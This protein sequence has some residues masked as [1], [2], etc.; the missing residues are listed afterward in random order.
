MNH[1]YFN[2][3]LNKLKGCSRYETNQNPCYVQWYETN[4]PKD[5][6]ILISSTPLALPLGQYQIR[7]QNFNVFNAIK[8]VTRP[9]LK[10]DEEIFFFYPKLDSEKNTKS[11]QFNIAMY[12]CKR[13]DKL[14]G[15]STVMC[16]QFYIHTKKKKSAT[17]GTKKCI[18]S[19]N[20]EL[21]WIFIQLN[22]SLFLLFFCIADLKFFPLFHSPDRTHISIHTWIETH[23]C[24]FIVHIKARFIPFIYLLPDLCL[25]ATF[26][27]S[28][29][30]FFIFIGCVVILFTLKVVSS[31]IWMRNKWNTD[32]KL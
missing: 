6:N 3:K 8:N 26:L 30:F 7:W 12:A 28:E 20:R 25:F 15:V 17:E 4:Q 11:C 29:S 5:E 32:C 2:W 1:Y 23:M 14:L 31:N 18:Q 21:M 24:I 9:H 22:L 27:L 16:I 13:S 19:P 10:A